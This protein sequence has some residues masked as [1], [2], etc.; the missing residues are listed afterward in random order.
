MV[1]LLERKPKDIGQ[2]IPIEID[3][4][5]MPIEQP[6]IT[7]AVGVELDGEYCRAVWVQQGRVIKFLRTRG[8]NSADALDQ[9][10]QQGHLSANQPVRICWSSPG[11]EFYKAVQPPKPPSQYRQVIQ[12]LAE[13]S[14][15]GPDY[16]FAGQVSPPV[17]GEQRGV[18]AGIANQLLEPIW[19]QVAL[20]DRWQLIPSCLVPQP[21][22]LHVA[23]RWSVC[24]IYVIQDGF[25]TAYAE[26]PN[27]GLSNLTNKVDELSRLIEQ[28]QAQFSQNPQQAPVVGFMRNIVSETYKWVQSWIASGE[29]EHP[30]QVW[31]HGE[32]GN[33][34][35]LYDALI[36]TWGGGLS[37]GSGPAGPHMLP[38]GVSDDRQLPL[39]QRAAMYTA[40]RAAVTSI[41]DPLWIIPS[42]LIDRHR[43]AQETRRKRIKTATELIAAVVVA[44]LAVSI[45]VVLAYQQR[46]DAQA[47]LSRAQQQFVPL[48]G[49]YHTWVV[50]NEGQ[51]LVKQV[52]AQQP[53]LA[54]LYQLVN[55][56]LPPSSAINTLEAQIPK[57]GG[58]MQVQVQI[59]IQSANPLPEVSSWLQTLQKNK[60][61]D[62]T[63]EPLGQSST[64]GSYTIQFKYTPVAGG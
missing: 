46:S 34:P 39:Q 21:D 10:I 31:L 59:N 61:Q 36:K 19:E 33:L 27:R 22:G 58:P 40:C 63:S 14:L 18:V 56:T 3:N 44:I 37:N 26:M 6:Q 23:L 60:A 5:M 55:S 62:L 47:S 48:S 15:N 57:A 17:E 13:R 8:S 11:V 24:A 52:K 29:I 64:G 28:Q 25:L 53:Q 32:G 9:M 38:L 49:D 41:L 2:P 7:T 54:V 16:G 20:R 42:P 12:E 35:W 45:P 50:V 30:K 43:R 4:P 1:K 51:N